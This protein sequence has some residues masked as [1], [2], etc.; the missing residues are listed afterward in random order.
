MPFM[1]SQLIEA[2]RWLGALAVL[3]LH[4]NNMFVNQADIMSAPHAAP[5]YVWWFFTGSAIGHQAVVGFFVLSGW[6]VGGAV[7]A[8]IGRGEDFLRS[9]FIHRI[10]RVYVVLVPALFLT[11]ALDALGRGL[12]SDAG[13]YDQP[14]FSGHSSAGLFLASVANLQGIVFDHFG[15]NG[16][17]WSL[18][19]EFWY[20]VCFPLLLLPFA[21]NYAPAPRFASFALGLALTAGLLAPQSWFGFGF[22]IWGMGAFSTRAS[23]PLIRS[24][25][26]ALLMLAGGVAL[27]RLLARGPVLVAHPWLNPASD[28]AAAALFVNALLA[29]RDA[30][31]SGFAALHSA[32][33][34]RLADFS[35]SVYAVHMPI[36]IF[37]RAAVA[38][39]MGRDWPLQLA[40]GANYAAALVVLGTTFASAYLFSRLTEAKTGAARRA[41]RGA[42][43]R[44]APPPAV[45]APVRERATTGP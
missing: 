11:L 5:A 33:H 36:V 44:L 25:W 27:I 39:V 30:P 13:V 28:L 38:H 8:R 21:R 23:R 9:Y 42:L 17:L 32:F 22:V 29:F 7:L 4:V 16:P 2:A 26:L 40:T 3:S 35:F 15:S 10:S 43:D 24:R 41:L 45:P 34:A 12:F 18:A 37:L 31:Q 20:Y 14:A 1:L 19:C 6:L